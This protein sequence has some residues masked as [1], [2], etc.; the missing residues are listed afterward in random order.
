LLNIDVTVYE[1][2]K[3]EKGLMDMM[4]LRL[5]AIKKILA[6]FS[7]DMKRFE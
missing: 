5:D 2:P 6:V 4:A 1:K 7:Y 3:K